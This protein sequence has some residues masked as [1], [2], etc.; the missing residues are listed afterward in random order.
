MEA[1][2]LLLLEGLTAK[3]HSA[4]HSAPHSALHSASHGME[5]AVLLLLE[6][7]TAKARS[8]AC[9]AL[10]APHTKAQPPPYSLCSLR[11]PSALP[12]AYLECCAPTVHLLRAYCV[13]RVL[14]AHGVLTAC[15][16]CTCQAHPA[17]HAALTTDRGHLR[18]HAPLQHGGG[19]AAAPIT[20]VL[21]KG[22]GARA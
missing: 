10:A 8:C 2:V 6:G 19:G 5:A 13:P 20:V 4:S 14:R 21:D 18:V 7:L 3:V 12:A 16:L 11:L 9:R 15:L 22:D 1:A 17:L